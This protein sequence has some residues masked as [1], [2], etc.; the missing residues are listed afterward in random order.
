MFERKSA[1]KRVR[2]IVAD[3]PG[4]RVGYIGNV[5]PD[6]RD[7]RAWSIFLG[8]PG[9]VGG[10]EDRIGSFPTDEVSKLVPLALALRAGFELG[11]EGVEGRAAI[12]Q[13]RERARG[14]W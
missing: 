6:G 14:A 12:A 3:L 7:D 4:V 9:R 2:E 8:H 11:A 5:Y 13:E 1:D 10:M